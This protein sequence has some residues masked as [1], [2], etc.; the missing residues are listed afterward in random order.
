[1]LETRKGNTLCN[2]GQIDANAFAQGKSY[3]E[4]VSMFCRNMLT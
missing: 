2:R 3:I 1:M 4:Y